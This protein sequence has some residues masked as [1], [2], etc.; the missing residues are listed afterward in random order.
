VSKPKRDIAQCTNCQK[1]RYTWKFCH[2]KPRCVKC[3]I[4]HNTADC[5]RKMQS[6]NMKCVLC[7]GNQLQLTIKSVLSLKNYRKLNFHPWGKKNSTNI[8][9]VAVDTT[10]QDG[11]TPTKRQ[12]ANSV[13]SVTRATG[14][15]AFSQALPRRSFFASARVRFSAA[16]ACLIGNKC[17]LRES[18]AETAIRT[19]GY[20]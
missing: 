15:Y 5:P 18:F 9:T 3:A 6:D 10:P 20:K 2:C 12:T 14:D 8:Q 13:T 11:R 7:N 1:Y 19:V 16:S 17:L 4:E